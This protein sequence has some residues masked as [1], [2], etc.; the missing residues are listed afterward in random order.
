MKKTVIFSIFLASVMFAGNINFN[1]ADKNVERINPLVNSENKTISFNSSIIN[2]KK[3][4]VNIAT[5]QTIKASQNQIDPFFNDPFFNDFFKFNFGIPKTDRKAKSLGSGVIISNDGYIVTNNHVVENAD[6]IIVT[7]SESDKEFKAKLI[8]NDPKTDIAII[9]IDKKDLTAIKFGDS[10]ELLEG[11]MVFAIGNP[12]GVGE[13]ITQG[14]IS[15]LNKNNIGLNQYENFIQTDASINPGNSGGALVD[16]RGALIG[17]NSAILSSS[18]GNNGVGFAIPSNMVKN[19]ASKLIKDGKIERGYIGVMI[20]NLNEDQKEIYKNEEGA[21]IASVEKNS[22]A[23]KA[24]L[25]RGDL[26]VKINDKSIKNAN[27]LK[28]IIGSMSPGETIEV[29]Y[30]RAKD[31][32]TAKIKLDNMDS[33]TLAENTESKSSIE[34]LK[35]SNLTNELKRQYNI[36]SDIKG[37]IITNVEKGSKAED[38]GFERGDIIMQIAQKEIKTIADIDEAIKSNKGKKIVWVLRN[39]IPLGIVIK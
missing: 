21:L 28:N 22:P 8:G 35:L 24:G 37:V 36:Q 9:K 30:E 14:I 18:G 20:S 10:G 32:K 11:D 27:E 16:S 26:I 15:A 34:G 2:A 13:T 31:T 4:V 19:I 3:S 5:S 1:E 23:D 39:E 6:E 25:K 38:Y 17:I 33:S 29:Q 12:F 7:L